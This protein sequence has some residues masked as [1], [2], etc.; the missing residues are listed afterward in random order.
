MT[1]PYFPVFRSDA[2]QANVLFFAVFRS[3]AD[4]AYQAP[5]RPHASVDATSLTV[6]RWPWRKVAEKLYVSE[7]TV[8]TIR[9]RVLTL[10]AYEFGMFQ[11]DRQ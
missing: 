1:L 6:E 7:R 3:D 2:K 11:P 4:N 10:L 5:G 9:D 8:N